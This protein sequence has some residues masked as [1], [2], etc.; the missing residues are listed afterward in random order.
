MKSQLSTLL[1][2]CLA[3]LLLA[4]LA[5]AITIEDF[6]ITAPANVSHDAGSLTMT[7]V[8]NNTG[9]TGTINLTNAATSGSYTTAFSQSNP[10][11]LNANQTTT[12]TATLTFAKHQSGSLAGTITANPS[13]AGS[14]KS[15]SFSIPILSSN[16]LTATKIRDFSLTQNA[17][18]NISNTGNTQLSNI[19][20]SASG[21]LPVKLSATTLSLGP[22]QSQTATIFLE[23][24]SSLI[25]GTNSVTFRAKDLTTNAAASDLTLNM[26]KSFCTQGK[27]G[28]NLSLRV[29][30]ESSG[31][32]DFEWKPLD[33]I[34]VDV[35]VEYKGNKDD[36]V[37]DIIVELGLFSSDGR[38]VIDDVDFESADKEETEIGDLDY[39]DDTATATFTFIV[40]AD[41]DSGNYKFAVKAYGDNV[42]EKVECVDSSQDLQE[43]YYQKI[44]VN[45]ENDE[46]KFIAFQNAKITP[47][48]VTCKD[49]VT[50]TLDVYNV[51]DEDQDQVLVILQNKELGIDLSKEIK[52]DLD[53]GDKETISFTFVIPSGLQDKVYNLELEARYDF[54]K[55]TYRESSDEKTIVPLKVFGCGVT[56]ALTKTAIN[57]VLD[58][59]AQ[60]GK[61]LVVK[62]T[63]TNQNTQS[64]DYVIDVTGYE[65]WAKLN[66]ISE[67]LISLP[68]AQTK[69]ITLKFAINKDAEGQQTFT[70]KAQSG[71]ELTAR[72]IAVNIEES[73]LSL[74]KGNAWLWV[75]GI[76]NVILIILIIIVAV[77]VAS[78]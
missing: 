50:L 54:S 63:I 68:V 7:F 30:I 41:I 48:D 25:F 74:F 34:T 14:P 2:A 40:P 9:A 43:T 24:Q 16:S 45:K 65:S 10:I 72:Q 11:S 23:D 49:T 27:Q 59:E 20:L 6:V 36:E 38:N 32:E 46:G 4:N 53:Q 31:K 62:A 55:D 3:S 15:A 5:A 35:D 13:G 26:V 47:T 33:T 57:A 66:S 37:E 69:E 71:A 44:K 60:A 64:K 1:L 70:I 52:T 17:S 12:I 75:I 28:N 21:S 51:G 18:V 22:G 73:T 56:P 58:S 19:N 76:V 8:L 61:E 77:R 42:G 29:D 39:D 67:R 78:R